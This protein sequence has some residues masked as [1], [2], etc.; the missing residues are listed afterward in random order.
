MPAEVDPIN[1]TEQEIDH[2][3][4][5]KVNQGGYVSAEQEEVFRNIDLRQKS[6]V[7]HETFH[8]ALGGFPVVSHHNVAAEQIGGVEGG[9]SSE[10][11]REH[12]SHDQQGQQ[13]R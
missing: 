7:A 11:L 3:R 10:K 1:G 8:A 5:Q 13:R 9:V 12:Q 2:Q 4:Q 6:G